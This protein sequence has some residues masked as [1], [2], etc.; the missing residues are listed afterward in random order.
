MNIKRLLSPAVIIAIVLLSTGA[1]GLSQVIK[2]MGYHLT[3]LPIYPKGDE[4]FHTFP[5]QFPSW[6]QVGRDAELSKEMIE[7]L[8]TDNTISRVYVE[9][10]PPAGREPRSVQIHVAYYTGMID[11]VPHVPERC[12]VGSGWLKGDVTST[13]PVPLNMQRLVEEPLDEAKHKTAHVYKALAT[14]PPGRVRL[15]FG[16]DDLHLTVTPFKFSSE[17]AL[18]AGYFFIANGGVV[19]SSNQVR[20]LAFK[21]DQ[22]YAFYCKIQFSS[23]DV[24]SAEELGTLAGQMLDE[25]FGDI[26]R[27]VPDWVE[28]QEGRWPLQDQ[29][30]DSSK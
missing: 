8:G 12:L 27:R 30:Q 22:R 29:V 24:N 18:Y 14:S 11:T 16:A 19:A 3:K 20:L 4:K 26:M 6:K 2:S 23:T 7:E 28:V 10:N 1:I 17:R 21:L 13:V 15:P 5:D 9:T 25:M